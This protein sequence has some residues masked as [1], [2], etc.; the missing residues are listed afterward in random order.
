ML[1][2]ST[3]VNHVLF[4]QFQALSKESGSL[5]LSVDEQR[6][7]IIGTSV[8]N[9]ATVF[10]IIE[11]ED[12]NVTISYT[13]NKGEVYYWTQNTAASNTEKLMLSKKEEFKNKQNQQ[14]KLLIN[15]GEGLIKFAC[16]QGHIY[17]VSIR[18]TQSKNTNIL[19]ASRLRSSGDTEIEPGCK[20]S[21]A[22]PNETFLV[23]PADNKTKV[24][25]MLSNFLQLA[26]GSRDSSQA[27]KKVTVVTK[28]IKFAQNGPE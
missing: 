18:L 6:R 8:E 12:T 22:P 25:Y 24:V 3:K 20:I 19:C 7:I 5:W 2:F 10:T 21:R 28:F 9:E 13:N 26:V 4:Y 14:F 17:S 15:S 23:Y 11:D 1:Y 27:Q 16:G